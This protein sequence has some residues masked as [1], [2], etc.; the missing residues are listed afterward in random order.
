MTTTTAAPED[1]APPRAKAWSRTS[2]PGPWDVIVVGSGMGG[3]TA[4]ALLSALGRRVLVLEQHYV[5]GGFTHAFKRKGWTWDVGVHAVGE[6]TRHSL[7]G[8]LLERLTGGRLR[9]ASLG[10][11]YDA[12]EFP[13]GFKI[14]FP[15]SP[16]QFRENLVRA[17]PREQ[18]AIDGY[19]AKVNEVSR[20]MK[21]YYLA[22]TAP[23]GLRRV[24]DALLAGPARRAFM[25]PAGEVID[26]LTQDPRLRA[27]L[28]AQWGYYGVTPAKASFAI[29]AL[30]AKHFMHGGYYPVGGSAAIADELLGAV[31]RAGGWT[32]IVADVETIVVERGRARGVRLKGGEELRAPVVVSATGVLATVLRLLPAEQRDAPW[33]RD[34]AALRPAAAHVCLYHG[35]EG[36]LRAAGGGAANQWFYETWSCEED[37]WR[38]AWREASEGGESAPLPR[39]PVLYTSFPS[40]KDPSHDPGPRRLHTAEV[41]TFVPWEAFEPWRDSRWHRRGEEYERFKARLQTSMLEQVLERL[42]GLRP[43]VRHAELSTPLSTEHFCR[44][45]EGS[46][47]GLAP[48]PERFRTPW[49]RPRS[50]IPGLFFAGSEVATCGVIGAMMGGVLAAVAAEPVR[51]LRYIAQS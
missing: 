24:A 30:V 33:C 37:A 40:L 44:P 42:P 49:L 13:D 3:M 39:A 31:A 22:R 14:D 35:L 10:P 4:A 32:R 5:P 27:V 34:V 18:A 15:D 46:I 23:R 16:K 8:R 43:L 47:Y 1:L 17:F 50:E 36:D 48:T 26:G 21:G 9:W 20:A 7:T 25:Q 38:V 45:V 19:L 51:A 28:T 11:V 12:F 29:Q 41:V 2:P 6:V